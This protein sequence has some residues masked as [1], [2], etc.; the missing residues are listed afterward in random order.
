[1]KVLS[2][3][4]NP[5]NLKIMKNILLVFG[6][7]FLLFSCEIETQK[8]PLE[9]ISKEKKYITFDKDELVKADTIEI[10]YV[11]SGTVIFASVKTTLIKDTVNNQYF[12][13]AY[14]SKEKTLVNKKVPFDVVN[15]VID[16]FP[17]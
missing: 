12:L 15:Y 11:I 2:Y 9:Q 3:S 4:Q 13:S 17:K 14:Y 6:L 7:L 1:M 10:L 5:K 16:I 8:P